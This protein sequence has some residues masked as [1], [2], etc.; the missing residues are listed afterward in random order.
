MAKKPFTSCGSCSANCDRLRLVLAMKEQCLFVLILAMHYWLWLHASHN[1]TDGHQHIALISG[2]FLES[3]KQTEDQT[4]GIENLG[5]ID[6]QQSTRH[7]NKCRLIKRCSERE[8]NWQVH[9]ELKINISQWP[10]RQCSWIERCNIA[11][12]F[13]PS[14]KRDIKRHS[15]AYAIAQ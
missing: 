15:I 10:F 9:Y 2:S 5:D 13:A 1:K 11:N 12:N 3:D 4:A 6:K 8:E 14:I 7:L